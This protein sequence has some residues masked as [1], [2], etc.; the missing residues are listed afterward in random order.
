MKSKRL[1]LIQVT[2]PL[3]YAPKS[4]RLPLIQVTMPL[5]Y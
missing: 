4:K 1:P 2:M 5:V 3:V